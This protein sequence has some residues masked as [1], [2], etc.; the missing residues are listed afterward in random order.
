MISDTEGAQ[1]SNGAVTESRRL[2]LLDD[3]PVFHSLVAAVC[4]KHQW[5]LTIAEDGWDALLPAERQRPKFVLLGFSLGD[6]NALQFLYDLHAMCPDAPLGLITGDAP[7]DIADVIGLAG[8]TAELVK[9]CAAEEVA[10]L[11]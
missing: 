9:P 3:D 6:E 4:E 11:I 7:D 2:L 10:G 8:G 1:L 5:P